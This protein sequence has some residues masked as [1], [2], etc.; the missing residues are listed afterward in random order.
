M[1]VINPGDTRDK[2]RSGRNGCLTSTRSVGLVVHEGTC[3]TENTEIRQRRRPLWK[4]IQETNHFR[5][6]KKFWTHSQRD[7]SGD[8][9]GE[10]RDKRKRDGGVVKHP[11]SCYREK[12]SVTQ[13]NVQ[14]QEDAWNRKGTTRTVIV[15][16]YLH[17][18]FG[19]IEDKIWTETGV[20]FVGIHKIPLQVVCRQDLLPKL[21]IICLLWD[22]STPK[23]RKRTI[24]NTGPITKRRIT[25]RV[26]RNDYKAPTPKLVRW[27]TVVC[28]G[29]AL[30]F[31]PE[32]WQVGG[33]FLG[34]PLV[35]S[36][37][38]RYP[39]IYI[40]TEGLLRFSTFS[41]LPVSSYY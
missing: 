27:Q 1:C 36:F 24:T 20:G 31:N 8:T 6:C 35:L 41:C 38:V 11:L 19:N 3:S 25:R 39:F 10:S 37:V 2:R 14:I 7:T 32:V 5:M 30:G 12:S 40:I 9:D 22:G 28:W 34:V 13:T 17:T 15:P 18:P 4:R 26:V 33:H 16:W 29:V 21:R 23:R